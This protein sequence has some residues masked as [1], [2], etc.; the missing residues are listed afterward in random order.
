M[1][2]LGNVTAAYSVNGGS[3]V[4]VAGSFHLGAN[5]FTPTSRAGIVTASLNNLAAITIPF[6]KFDIDPGTTAVLHP[7]VRSTNI[8]PNATGVMLDSAVTAD[9]NLPNAGLNPSTVNTTNVQLWRTSDHAVVAAVVNT[10]GGGDSIVLQPANTLLPNTQYPFS[11][12]S[13]VADTKG[14]SF[15]PYTFNFTT[16]NTQT[17]P[18]PSIA[19]VPQDLPSASG[20]SFTGVRIGPDH[21]L[22]GS[23]LDGR[24]YRWTINADGTL[25][26]PQIITSLQTANAGNRLI[27]GFAFDP[28]ATAANPIIWVSNSYFGFT[29]VRR[30]DRQNHRNEWCGSANR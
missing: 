29:N 19:F 4:S 5:F 3:F 12:S 24:I 18:D 10:S 20:T 6:T 7:S 26:T 23:T 1:L 13:G 30:L 14:V 9:L 17:Q 15:T 25:G 11:V 8:A 28:A 16:G 22:Y 27:T 2:Q 21:K